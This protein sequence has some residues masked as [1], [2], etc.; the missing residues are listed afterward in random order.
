MKTIADLNA[1]I[2]ELIDLVI[3][4]AIIGDEEDHPDTN[5]VYDEDGWFIDITYQ[6]EGEY[7]YEPGDYWTPES[8]GLLSASGEIIRL[9]ASHYDEDTE[10]ETEFSEYDVREL[11]DALNCALANIA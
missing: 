1:L 4:N 2:P 3:D 7:F 9:K 10:E 11:C 8:S 6:C 5:L